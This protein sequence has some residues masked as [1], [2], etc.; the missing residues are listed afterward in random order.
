[1]PRPFPP[2]TYNEKRRCTQEERIAESTDEK[3]RDC[4]AVE[5]HGDAMIGVVRDV[6]VRLL[7]ERHAVRDTDFVKGSTCTM[8]ACDSEAERLVFEPLD[9]PVVVGVENVHGAVEIDE[10]DAWS[11]ELAETAASS[12]SE[13]SHDG[14]HRSSGSAWRE[15]NDSAVTVVGDE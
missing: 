2:A 14:S 8:T 3:S 4:V 11:V 1:M 12:R 5:P 9:H 6:D 10:D 7:I 15:H 13:A